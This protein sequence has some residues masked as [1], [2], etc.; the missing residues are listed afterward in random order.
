MCPLLSVLV[1]SMM[2]FLFLLEIIMAKSCQCTREKKSVPMLM[3]M[4]I[5]ITSNSVCKLLHLS[6]GTGVLKKLLL[7][8]SVLA[9]DLGCTDWN[10]TMNTGLIFLSMLM[11]NCL[12]NGDF[13]FSSL[14]K[15]IWYVWLVCTIY[16]TYT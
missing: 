10:S 12:R 8:Q 3:I 1:L 14:M 15:C 5:V 9:L 11:E 7:K 6:I 2:Q 16:F 13:G 4:C